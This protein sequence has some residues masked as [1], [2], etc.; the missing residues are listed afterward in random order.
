MKCLT[1][2]STLEFA[3]EVTEVLAFCAREAALY[4][5]EFVIRCAWFFFF[6]FFSFPDIALNDSRQKKKNR[7]MAKKERRVGEILLSTVISTYSKNLLIS[8]GNGDI[9]CDT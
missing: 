3:A 6:F 9:S 2:C 1:M 4:V 5:S 8:D 7:D